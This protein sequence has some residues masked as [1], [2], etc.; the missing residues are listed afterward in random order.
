MS[1]QKEHWVICEKT[2]T[3]VLTLLINS[4]MAVGESFYLKDDSLLYKNNNN[5]LPNS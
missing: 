3:L 4:Y 2:G 1:F 5:I